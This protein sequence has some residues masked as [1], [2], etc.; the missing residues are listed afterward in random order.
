MRTGIVLFADDHKIDVEIADTETLR[1][2]GLMYRSHLAED[3]G[4]LFVYPDQAI[5][6]VW[7]KNTLIPLDVLF[8]SEDGKI[9]TLLRSLEPCKQ[10]PCPISVS[11]EKAR[12]MLEVNA[13]FIDT[14]RIKTGQEV[15]IDYKHTTQ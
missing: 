7:M 4:M 8:L 11:S 9:V 1:T 2:T 13:G 3:Q 10:I 15:V 6:G 12:Y 14:H 5:R